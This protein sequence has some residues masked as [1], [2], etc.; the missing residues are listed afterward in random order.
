[1]ICV[2]NVLCFIALVA[3]SLASPVAAS[4]QNAPNTIG[5]I[6]TPIEMPF[7]APDFAFRDGDGADRGIVEYR[8]KAVVV[9]FWATWCAVCAIDMPALDKLQGELAPDDAQVVA[10]SIDKGSIAAVEAYLQHRRLSNLATYQD[11]QNILAA[12]FGIRGTPT[13]FLIDPSG[14]VVGVSEGA[15][16]WSAATTREAIENLK[17]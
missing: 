8:G 5:G 9:Y 15:A 12:V 14:Q 4:E 6:F 11:S 13:A 16:D 2:E 10:L 17:H 7:P 1:M 3:A